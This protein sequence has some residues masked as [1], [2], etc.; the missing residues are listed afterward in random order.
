[1]WVGPVSVTSKLSSR[2]KIGSHVFLS[3][4][5]GETNGMDKILSTAQL[6][7]LFLLSWTATTTTLLPL[8]KTRRKPSFSLSMPKNRSLVKGT[9]GEEW[10]Q[11]YNNTFVDRSRVKNIANHDP[12]G[13]GKEI[14]RYE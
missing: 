12:V 5:P 7:A 14:M 1:M 8:E 4:F 2:R 10:G 6:A 13:G 3:W 9:C 11:S